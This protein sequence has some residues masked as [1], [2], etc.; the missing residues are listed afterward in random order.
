MYYAYICQD[1]DKNG[2]QIAL[3]AIRGNLQG[4]QNLFNKDW[5]KWKYQV[6]VNLAL[7]TLHAQNTE[8]GETDD[9]L[10][11]IFTVTLSLTHLV[12]LVRQNSILEYMLKT[13][14]SLGKWD[15]PVSV[16]KPEL[17]VGYLKLQIYFSTC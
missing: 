9:T 11:Q 2:K 7:R 10:G 5:E 12:A 16:N 3:C 14:H 1:E 8:L 4:F 13:K 15:I 6:E 17:V